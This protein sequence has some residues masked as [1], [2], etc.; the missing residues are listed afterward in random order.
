MQSNSRRGVQLH[1]AIPHRRTGNKKSGV[2]ECE[3]IEYLSAEIIVYTRDI[4]I[5]G[6]REV[7]TARVHESATEKSTY[8]GYNSNKTQLIEKAKHWV[9]TV[10]HSLKPKYITILPRQK[11]WQLWHGPESDAAQLS[12]LHLGNLRPQSSDAAAG[13][14][15]HPNGDTLVS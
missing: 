3:R 2:S 15:T 13:T 7:F 6:S 1:D 12:G 8:L 14:D 4:G 9:D 10:K 5:A 11:A